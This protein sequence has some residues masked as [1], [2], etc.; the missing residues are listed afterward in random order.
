LWLGGISHE[1]EGGPITGAI[2]VIEIDN[3][4]FTQD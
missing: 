1:D 4:F 3:K 2:T